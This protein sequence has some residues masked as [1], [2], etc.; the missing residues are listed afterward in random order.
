LWTGNVNVDGLPLATSD[1]DRNSKRIMEIAAEWARNFYACSRF[2]RVVNLGDGPWYL[3]ASCS[4]GYAF[5]GI[6]PRA[7]AL[8]D[9]EAFYWH[10]DYLEVEA[11]L[12]SIAE[13]LKL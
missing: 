2:E 6:G 11:V 13:A 5:I 1:D 9:L 8:K 12:V 3:Q 10:Q 7:Q 4:L